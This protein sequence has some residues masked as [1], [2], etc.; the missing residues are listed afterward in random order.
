[1]GRRKNEYRVFVVK[2][3]ARRVFGTTRSRGKTILK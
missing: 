2:P 3:E 1:M